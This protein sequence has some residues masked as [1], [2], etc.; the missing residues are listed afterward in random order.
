MDG[1]EVSKFARG[2]YQKLTESCCHCH[3]TQPELIDQHNNNNRDQNTK[4]CE[5]SKVF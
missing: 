5:L 2:S 1:W 3:A 4:T